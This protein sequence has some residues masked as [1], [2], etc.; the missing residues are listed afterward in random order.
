MLL[1]RITAEAPDHLRPGGFLLLVTSSI[2]GTD[3]TLAGLR[4]AGL[5]PAIVAR[6]R[7]PLGPLM[8]RRVHALEA[9]GM[10]EPG[11]RH[12]DVLV[13]RARKPQRDRWRLPDEL[14][15]RA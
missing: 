10:I 11:V 8:Q 6:R 1:D 12:E 4:D 13:I 14:I 5:D 15:V 2:L 7:G 9:R 3:Q